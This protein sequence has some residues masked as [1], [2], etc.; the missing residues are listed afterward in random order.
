MA[1]VQCVCPCGSDELDELWS[2]VRRKPMTV[3]REG[4]E[5]TWEA[6]DK[7]LD[8]DGDGWWECSACKRSFY[9]LDE[10]RPVTP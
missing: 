9:D 10:F 5:M 4:D 1:K 8:S 3:Y 7:R 6:D 2:G